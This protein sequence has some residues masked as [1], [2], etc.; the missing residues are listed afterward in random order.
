[1]GDDPRAMVIVSTSPATTNPGWHNGSSNNYWASSA[2][3]H[4]KAPKRKEQAQ[5]AVTII[6]TCAYDARLGGTR[7]Q[8][9]SSSYAAPTPL[10]NFVNSK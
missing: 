4:L 9:E 8:H 2:P 3:T 10:F 5:I 7:P 6:G 1:M